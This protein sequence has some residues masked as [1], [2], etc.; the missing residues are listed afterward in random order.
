[1]TATKSI[2]YTNPVWPQYFAD[3]FVL[4]VEGTYW[5]YGTAP[6]DE[7]GREFPVL[8]SQ[9]LAQWEYVAHALQPS[10]AARGHNHWAPEVA[11]KD[12]RFYLY[13]SAAPRDD[14]Q[15]HRLRVAIA[16][17]PQ[18]PFTDVG[19]SLMPEI[20][21]SIDASPFRDPRTGRWYLFFATDYT[22][23]APYGTGLGMVPL[24]DD[25]IHVVGQ[26]QPVVRASCPWQI[27]ERNRNY[28]GKVWEAWNCVEGPFVLFHNDRYYCLY[29][30]GAWHSENYGVGFAVADNP[31]GPWIDEMAQRGP[32]VL[33]GAP[34][35][36]IGPGHNSVV[37]GPDNRTL[38]CV[39]HAWDDSRTAR[40]MCIDPLIWTPDG[41][42]VD[43]PSTEPRTL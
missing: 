25:L 11:E 12:G 26:P 36:V 40:R 10:P 1:M 34:P 21:F 28:K 6:A 7:A 14:D 19:E 43:G 38:F 15:H 31:M 13:Y 20:G 30:G 37:L 42:K 23:D 16:D 9:N 5:A 3:P 39:Y 24:A 41:P 2:T 33:K 35:K 18:G 22:E 32:T 17:A 8:R 29:S 4:R 27:Y